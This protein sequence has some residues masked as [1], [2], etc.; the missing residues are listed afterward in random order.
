[1]NTESF[2]MAQGTGPAPALP[3]GLAGRLAAWRALD[4]STW[5]IYAQG[6][7]PVVAGLQ[8]ESLTLMLDLPGATPMGTANYHYMVETGVS[9]KNLEEFN[10][11]YDTEHAPGL[12]RVPGTIRARRFKRQGATPRFIACYDLTELGTFERPEWLA[13]RG[14][15]WSDR[16]RPMFQAPQR[17]MYEPLPFA[18]T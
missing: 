6:E 18:A 3:A 2:W 17:T 16:V 1:M 15:A 10:A 14:T 9:D 7:P 5:R 12:S 13:I 4:G 11:W 8:W